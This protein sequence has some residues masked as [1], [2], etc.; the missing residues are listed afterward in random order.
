[1]KALVASCLCL[2]VLAGSSSARAPGSGE[3]DEPV[4]MGRTLREWT[5]DLKDADPEVR[6]HAAYTLSRLGPRI[7]R[8]F[9][10]LKEALR[11]SD[12]TVRQ[13]AAEALGYTGPQAL[14]VLLDLLDSEESRYGAIT[15][16]QHMEPDALPEVLRRLANGETRQRRAAAA[17]MRL[18]GQRSGEVGPALRLALNDPDG[19]VRVEAMESLRATRPNQSVA[20]PSI[21]KLLKD[22]DAEVRLRGIAM[23]WDA[24]IENETAIRAVEKLLNDPDKRIRVSAVGRLGQLD[25]RQSAAMLALARDGLKD[26]DEAVRERALSAIY[27]IVHGNDDAIRAALPDVM[28]FLGSHK[29]QPKKLIQ[30]I[31]WNL[32]SLEPEAKDIVPAL[33]SM[34]RDAEPE[35]RDQAARILAYQFSSDPAV[36][37]VLP[38]GIQRAPQKVR[39]EATAILLTLKRRPENLVPG[40]VDLL[41]ETSRAASRSQAA[42]VLGEMGP[43]AKEAMPALRSALED[44]SPMVRHSALL[45]ILRIEPDR[46]AEWVP[47]AI[48]ASTWPFSP[49]HEIIRTLQT[50]AGDVIPVLVKGLKD[51]DPQYRLRAGLLLNHMASARSVVTDLRVALENKDQAVRI[52]AA[53]TLA[54]INPKSE[55]IAPVLRAG[56]EFNDYAVREQVF[57]AIQSMGAAAREFAP[58]LIRFLKNKSEGQFRI[59]AAFAL[60]GINPLPEEVGTAFAAMVKDTDPQVRTVAL[61]CLNRMKLNDRAL[62]KILVDQFHDD[63]DGWQRHDLFNAIYQ[64]GPVASEEL[65]KRLND[66]NPLVRAAF[67]NLYLA[68]GGAN[69]DELYAA[70]DRALKDDALNVRLTA[71]NRL[72]GM[73]RES[74]GALKQVL[75]I[76]RQCLESPDLAVRQQAMNV[77]SNAGVRQTGGKASE[78][79]ISILVEQAKSKDARTRA[80]ALNALGHLRPQQEEMK[81]ILIQALEGNDAEV[82]RAAMNFL[83]SHHQYAK[84]LVP[85]L[86][87]LLNKKDERIRNELIDRLAEAGRGDPTAAAAL[88]EY[89]R[90]LNPSSHIRSSVL[91][92]LAQCGDNAKDGIPLCVEALKEDNDHLKQIAV[93]TLMQLDPPNKML[94]SALV[95]VNGRERVGR[96]SRFDKT[97][98]PLGAQALKELCDILANDKDADRRAGAAIVLGTMVQDAKD[99]EKALKNAMKDANPRVRLLAADAYWLVMNDT[100]TPMPVMLAALKDKDISL[101]QWAAQDIAEMGKEATHAAPHLVKFLKDQDEPVTGCLIHALYQMGKEAA[102]AIPALVDIV[103]D[104]ADSSNRASA[105]R[106]LMP[107]GREAKDAVPGLLDMLK[108]SRRDRGSAAMALAKIATPAEALPALLEVFVELSRDEFDHEDYAVAEALHSFGPTVADSVAELLQHKRS[109]VRIRAIHVLVRFGKQ[110]PGIVPQLM[111]AMEDKDD[112]VALQAAEAVW[113]IDRRTE[114]LPH[115][116]RGLKAKSTHN[117]VRAARNLMNMGGDAR[118]AVPD[119]IAACKDRDTAVRREAYRTLKLLDPEEAKKLDDGEMDVSK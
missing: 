71:A 45:A 16:L 117:R 70:I 110:A 54:R 75:P 38:H 83:S 24:G 35:I 46:M 12:P 108:N 90:K 21:L 79:I 66:K 2:C 11:D 37:S 86:I 76:V 114:V 113:N 82:R 100:K 105:A 118:A 95:D 111:D 80:S 116:V 19:L 93:R 102:P 27:Q 17:A 65:S 91:S 63:P 14:P 9:P 81:P 20:L 47:Q 49:P 69:H 34:V 101:R 52:L 74:N 107:F 84:E 15:G 7:R 64:F 31:L 97:R 55:G 43:E 50:R 44:K 26:A 8:A 88:L 104:G 96:P 106:A 68:T 6:W 23:L 1:M 77:L 25:P 58:E 94:V 29:R 3:N 92:V 73:D 32:S 33:V 103:R 115:F 4:Y 42:Y 67:L 36:K 78:E 41:Q 89:Y 98:K 39:L 13:Y 48:R 51:P 5:A 59:Q 85:V 56:I 87:K 40:L 18:V 112:D 57:H 53:T 22:T 62:L 109:E 61:Q 60:Q 72:L 30:Q 99:A 10:A 119:L 28:A